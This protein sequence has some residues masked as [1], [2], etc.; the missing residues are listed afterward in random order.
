MQRF[1]YRIE[2]VAI[3]RGKPDDAPPMRA[4][5]KQGR[6]NRRVRQLT[7]RPAAQ[8][9]D[10]A[11]AAQRALERRRANRLLSEEDDELCRSKT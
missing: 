6:H 3:E 8:A 4:C 11:D 9:G 5:N 7:L 2:T 10:A 1:V